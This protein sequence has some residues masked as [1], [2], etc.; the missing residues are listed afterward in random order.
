[1][2][3]SLMHTNRPPQSIPEYLEQLRVALTGADPAL[4][5]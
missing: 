4:E 2:N 3:S 5:G 1:M